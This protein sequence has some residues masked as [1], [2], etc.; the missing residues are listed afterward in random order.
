MEDMWVRVCVVEQLLPLSE[1]KLTVNVKEHWKR[2]KQ[3]FTLYLTVI[4][5]AEKDSE[6]RAAL[7]LTVAE[8][9]AID[10]YNSM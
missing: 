5:A 8:T 3:R 7:F 9:D 4:G 10:V 6:Q 1:L 2:F